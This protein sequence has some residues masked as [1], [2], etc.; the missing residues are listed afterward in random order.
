M[1][2]SHGWFDIRLALL[3]RAG[4]EPI[5]KT[6]DGRNER[7]MKGSVGAEVRTLVSVTVTGAFDTSSR[8][9]SCGS[10]VTSTS[11]SSSVIRGILL[12]T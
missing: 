8:V 9:Q 5:P 7:G 1:E 6:I 12:K 10:S 3:R 2:M 4:L 11:P